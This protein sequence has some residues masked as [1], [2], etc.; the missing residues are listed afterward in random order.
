MEDFRVLSKGKDCLIGEDAFAALKVGN[1]IYLTNMRGAEIAYEAQCKK[2]GKVV[3]LVPLA[4]GI[5]NKAVIKAVKH[6]SRCK[7]PKT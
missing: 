4:A 6:A 5:R 2:C 3:A 1:D 7:G